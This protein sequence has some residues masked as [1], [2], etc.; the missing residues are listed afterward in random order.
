MAKKKARLKLKNLAKTY[1]RDGVK[2][3][4]LK[5]LPNYFGKVLNG[6]KTFEIRNNDRD[7]K[8]GEY[9]ELLEYFPDEKKFT[10]KG[11]RA[12]ITYI[13][14]YEQKGNYVVFAFDLIEDILIKEDI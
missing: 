3:H 7:F 4:L 13:T 10:G 6:S 5:I 14:D 8:V 1:F 2:T 12:I 9:V 11:V